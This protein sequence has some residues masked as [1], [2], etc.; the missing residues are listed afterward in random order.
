ML[1]QKVLNQNTY[2][3]ASSKLINKKM[4]QDLFKDS[5]IKL[6][7]QPS[8]HG[9]LIKNNITAGGLTLGCPTAQSPTYNCFL[10]NFKM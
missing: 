10:N 7:G 1:K 9:K 5:A 3:A 8:D 2:L 6:T 4:L